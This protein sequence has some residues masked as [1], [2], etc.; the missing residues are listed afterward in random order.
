MVLE[1]E[2]ACPKCLNDNG[3]TIMMSKDAQTKAYSCRFGHKFKEDE[4]GY[5]RPQA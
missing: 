3:Y 4:R 2:A 1:S 5:L